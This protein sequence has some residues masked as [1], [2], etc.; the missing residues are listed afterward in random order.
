MAW[1][2]YVASPHHGLQGSIN[3]VFDME[4]QSVNYRGAE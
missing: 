3:T 4:A 2:D 1:L